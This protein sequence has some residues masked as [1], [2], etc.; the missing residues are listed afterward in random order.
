MRAILIYLLTVGTPLLGVFGVLHVGRD[1]RPTTSLAGE[2]DLEA[3]FAPLAGSPCAK[4][5]TTIKQP[6]L[7]I[8]QSGRRLILR[9]NNEMKTTLRG[10]FQG[11]ALEGG[12]RPS[13]PL[14]GD[15]SCTGPGA[16]YLEAEV[17]NDE[18]RPGNL[19]GRLMIA[20]CPGCPPVIFKAIRQQPVK[21]KV[22]S[23]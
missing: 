8:A 3:D 6:A 14:T 13:G 1:I 12:T 2:W 15:V 20:G 18:A 21:P 7:N 4:L 17:K 9:L 5:V 23:D 10:E 11:A 19:T 22:G 16:A